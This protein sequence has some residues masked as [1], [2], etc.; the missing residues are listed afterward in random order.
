[1]KIK[2]L[3]AVSILALMISHPAFAADPST[4]AIGGEAMASS[5]SAP[6]GG[7]LSDVKN[8]LDKTGATIDNVAGDIKVFFMGPGKLEPILIHSN[9]TAHGLL[10]SPIINVKGE[11]VA[12]V[13]DIIIDKGGKAILIVVSD[14]GFLGIGD[15][16]AAFDYDKV[17]TQQSDGKVIMSLSQNMVFHAADFSYEQKDWAKAKVIPAGS[18]SVDA[19]LKGDVLD[20]KG[21]KVANIDNVYIRNADVSQ[22]IVGFNKKLGMGG[23]LAALN[24][25]DLQMIKKNKTL[26]FKLTS[27]QT[28]QFSDF[29]KSVAN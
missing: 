11:K 18:I 19:L 10:G 28:T 14:G 29:K 1:M 24:Y 9:M 17:I 13:K 5:T 22:I 27:D 2:T 3:T 23:S 4:M 20:N 6:D 12:T 25:D 26:D 15:K 21:K 16:V 7:V 8:G